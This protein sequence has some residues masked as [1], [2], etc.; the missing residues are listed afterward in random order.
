[1]DFI[2]NTDYKQLTITYF[3]TKA[4]IGLNVCVHILHVLQDH[5]E[6]IKE[7]NIHKKANSILSIHTDKK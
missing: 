3:K 2:S 6:N 5:E 1:M 4:F 7:V